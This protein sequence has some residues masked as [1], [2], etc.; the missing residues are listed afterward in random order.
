[1]KAEDAKMATA[2]MEFNEMTKTMLDVSS[3][4]FD[5]QWKEK[6]NDFVTNFQQH[7]KDLMNKY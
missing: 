3:V 1:V 7:M 2:Q 5:N 4:A 6:K